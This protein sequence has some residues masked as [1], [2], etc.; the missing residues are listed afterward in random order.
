MP[1]G[2]A[3][4]VDIA[5]KNPR[6]KTPLSSWWMLGI[7]LLFYV[8][9]YLDR[10]IITMLVPP[11]KADL[12]LSDFETSLI[13]GPAFAICFGLFG[14]PLGWASDRYSRRWI[15]FLGVMVW[16]LATMGS[17]LAGGFI[18]LFAARSFVGVGEA[19]LT[20]AAYSLIGDKF[21]AHRVATA[22]SI[23]QMGVK[24]GSAA[25]FSLG[26]VAIAIVSKHEFEHLPLIGD[27]KP[28][29]L[30]FVLVG[31]PSV[32]LAFLCFTFS[33]PLRRGR[34]PGGD[35][36]FKD[37]FVFW[38]QHSALLWLMVVGFGLISLC[39]FSLTAWTPTYITRAFG[40]T[41]VQYGPALS[42]IS[43]LS[44]ATLVFKGALLD[45]MFARGIKDAYLR[46]YTW[47]LA[48]SI[49][50]AFTVYFVS[51]IYLFLVLFGII[52]VVTIPLMVY[53][54][55]TIHLLAPNQL[56]AQLIA[57][58]LLVSTFVGQGIGP[59]LVGAI[60]DF[61]FQDE[62]K[63]G[64]SLASILIVAVPTAFVVLSLARRHLLVAIAHRERE[65][66]SKE[67]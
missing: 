31:A 37:L 15:V 9:S 23:Y 30:V 60:T 46:L 11:I 56:R 52:Q 12:G 65:V 47:L 44:A 42:I 43:I 22:S 54:V 10:Y 59:M 62:A 38:R 1:M 55:P 49:P 14:L 48:G 25:A 66:Q 26:A 18:A 51:D 5:A 41:P 28:W 20:P 2:N 45:W 61:V 3:S 6:E 53:L 33:E 32:V 4:N 67:A 57:I 17:G 19:A 7:L 13:L 63:I 64:Y 40:W 21:P 8:I 35:T 16:S 27:M 39:A 24:L 36:N 34:A 29:Q 50:I 58:F